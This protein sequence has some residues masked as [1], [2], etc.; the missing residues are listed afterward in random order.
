MNCQVCDKKAAYVK[1]RLCQSCYDRARQVANITGEEIATCAHRIIAE[2]QGDVLRGGDALRRY[3]QKVEGST[4]ANAFLGLER[5]AMAD[6]K[7]TLRVQGF[8]YQGWTYTYEPTLVGGQVQVTIRRTPP[9]PTFT[10][11]TTKWDAQPSRHQ[12]A[13][14]RGITPC[15]TLLQGFHTQMR[16]VVS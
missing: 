3:V 13:S 7:A 16:G 10:S 2:G 11:L 1:A 12:D 9:D 4:H 15:S 14:R 6:A 8:T 5:K